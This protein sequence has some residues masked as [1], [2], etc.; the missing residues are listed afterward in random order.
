RRRVPSVLVDCSPPRWY[1]GWFHPLATTTP[2]QAEAHQ[3]GAYYRV[4]LAVKGKLPAPD[5]VVGGHAWW[6][7]GWNDGAGAF[8]GRNSWGAAWGLSGDFLLPYAY[9]GR[10]VEVWRT[11]DRG[12]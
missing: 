4:P 1:H 9:V 8:R 5:Y 2:D 6:R 7:R 10:M 11:L 12:A 3:I